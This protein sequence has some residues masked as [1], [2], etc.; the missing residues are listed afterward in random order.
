LQKKKNEWEVARGKTIVVIAP[1]A[2]S[3]FEIASATLGNLGEENPRIYTCV[4][5]NHRFPHKNQKP[6]QG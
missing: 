4:A 3:W 6:I 2:L 1:K 5:E